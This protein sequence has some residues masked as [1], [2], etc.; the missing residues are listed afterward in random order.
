MFGQGAVVAGPLG[1]VVLTPA[2]VAGVEVGWLSHVV[3][4]VDVVVMMI[5]EVE[6]LVSILVT[7]PDMWVLVNG[8]RVVDVRTLESISIFNLSRDIRQLT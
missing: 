1:L 7:L 4:T 3:Q 5:V 2:E 6:T 8:Q